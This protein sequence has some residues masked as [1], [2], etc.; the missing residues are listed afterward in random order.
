MELGHR[1]TET[2]KKIVVFLGKYSLAISPFKISRAVGVTYSHTLLCLRNLVANGI[3][4]KAGSVRGRYTLEGWVK[5]E[6]AKEKQDDKR[7]EI[8]ED[9]VI[10]S[11]KE[12]EHEIQT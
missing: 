4:R 8:L 6:I 7:Q 2:E 1:L 3:V 12:D 11:K 9:E 10:E 5:N